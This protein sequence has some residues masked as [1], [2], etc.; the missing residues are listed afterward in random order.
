MKFY[1]RHLFFLFPFLFG[2]LSIV[3]AFNSHLRSESFSQCC[4]R[5]Q[6][7]AQFIYSAQPYISSVEY[8]A[9]NGVFNVSGGNF[10][11]DEISNN[12]IDPSKFIISCG[13]SKFFISSS[14]AMVDV[15][16][17]VSFSFV[18]SASDLV[19]VNAILDFNGTKSKDGIVYNF[20]AQ[21][22][23][24]TIADAS[25]DLSSPTN[26]IAVSGVSNYAPLALNVTLSG[27]KVNGSLLTLSYEYKDYEGD[28]QG[29]A[30]IQWFSCS[31]NGDPNPSEISDVTGL[32][33]TLQSQDI[34]RYIYAQ[35]TPVAGNATGAAVNSNLIGPVQDNSA[36]MAS[37]VIITGTL[38]VCKTLHGAYDYSDVE[39]DVESASVYQW[40]TSLTAD[41]EK[42][43]ISGASEADYTLTVN[44]Q[45]KYVSFSVL[46]RAESG[47]TT[48]TIV[49]SGAAGAIVNILPTVTFSGS[50]SICEGVY[51]S[52]KLSFSGSS[53]WNLTYTDGTDQHQIVSND[54]IY[55][56]TVNKGGT[57]KGITLTDN[58]NCPVTDLN[59]SATVSMISLPEVEIVGLNSAY[60]VKSG[61]V[62]LTGSPTGGKFSGPGIIQYDNMFYP[63]I[64]G[65]E[66]SPYTIIYEYTSPTTGCTNRDTALVEVID[67]NASISGIRSSA[68]YCNYD[69]SFIITGTNVVD[70]IGS[71]TITGGAGL[72]DNNNN[73]ATLNPGLLVAGTYTITYTYVNTGVV[74]SISKQITVEVLDAAKIYGLSSTQYCQN[75]APIEVS[76]NYSGGVFT[77][78]SIYKNVETGKYYFSPSLVNSGSTNVLYTYTTSY[79]CVISKS[80]DKVI[81]SVPKADFSVRSVCFNGDSTAFQNSTTYSDPI[82]SWAW[83]FG[84]TQSSEI[85]NQSSRFEPKHKYLSAGNKTIQLIATNVSGCKDTAEKIIYLAGMPNAS[86]IG[87]TECYEKGVPVTFTSTSTCIDQI[88]NYYWDIEDTSVYNFY[89]SGKSIVR[90]TF[91][92]VR[93]YMVKLKTISEFGCSDSISKAESLKPI[94]SLK[95]SSYFND[96]E[97]GTGYWYN[98]DSTSVNNWYFGT[99]AGST[100]DAA[101]SGTKAFYTRLKDSRKNMQHII[102]S[103]CFNFSETNK[104]YISLQ[105]NSDVT[106]SQE[107]TVL[108]YTIDNGSTWSNV[109][110][111]NTGLNWYNNYAIVGQPGGQSIGWSSKTKGFV[112]SKHSLDFLTSESRVQFRLVYGEYSKASAADGFAV[113]DIRIDTRDKNVLVEHFTNNSQSESQEANTKLNE[114]I[115][116]AKDDAIDIQYHT[117]FPGVDTFNI[118][119]SADPGAR[120]LYYGI[121]YPPLTLLDGGTQSE[122]VFDYN[123]DAPE[124]A[125]V[126]ILAL[127]P[128]LFSLKIIDSKNQNTISGSIETTAKGSI[129]S[130]QIS[131]HIVVV[132]DIKSQVDG[133]EVVYRDVVKKMLPSAGGTPFNRAWAEGD[134]ETVNFTWDYKNVYNPQNLRL[135]AFLQDETSH[136][137]FQVG[138]DTTSLI[139]GV[140]NN[141]VVTGNWKALV[142]PNPV[143]DW[144][145][146]EFPETND[147]FFK[148]QIISLNGK[149][150]WEDNIQK[151]VS[152]YE[153]ETVN[154]KNG[155]Y[156]VRILNRNSVIS[157]SKLVI[158]H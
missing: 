67:A 22:G 129:T 51:T 23:W 77:G 100:I 69:P 94:Y 7:T 120:V 154:F 132:E 18:L 151:G 15:I 134:M 61:P 52:L 101:Y 111:Y 79:N 39:E 71:F 62:S 53:P 84:D 1:L 107:G 85:D 28:E 65:S 104:V 102:T 133:S 155:V 55:T 29:E 138:V 32:T 131:L 148:L 21:N 48:G 24:N 33:Y 93:N 66:N 75:V 31:G 20:E 34:D 17:D 73:T 128:A 103:P 97:H 142:F 83:T 44:E 78:S 152:R 9:L 58:L 11:S 127:S 123:P 6:L 70:A 10:V 46:P 63:S 56:L 60:N 96:F 125:D 3:F 116:L 143:S 95:D 135:V 2:N 144:L 126:D 37:N 36:P 54:N 82:S 16:N 86:F 156:F 124:K 99:P 4:R 157:T 106:N 88:A 145:N 150:V 91:P 19:N 81:L 50:A 109:G 146:I 5:E 105:T 90:H 118:H 26:S 45:G 139:D 38:A 25:S 43:E 119:N 14:T 117:S 59:S 35:I 98:A 113:D 137:I 147:T 130:R 122:D 108:Q 121:G 112:N 114:L 136:E 153:M 13:N 87:S 149:L 68:K 12:D 42:T 40:Y 110:G 49:Y 30:K 80:V 41:G 47:T 76:G 89:Y 140:E 64:V 158:V 92:I 141:P 74:L 8:D 115:A 72:T 57:Y 27:N